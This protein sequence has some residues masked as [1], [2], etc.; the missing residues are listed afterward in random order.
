MAND[1]LKDLFKGKDYPEDAFYLEK[2]LGRRTIILYGAGES[3]HWFVEVVIKGYGFTPYIVLDR[4]FTEESTF[5][6]IPAIHPDHFLATS[7]QLDESIIVI[8]SGNQKTACEIEQELNLK[9]F[10]HIISLHNIYEIH[11]PFS[12]PVELFDDGFSYYLNRESDIKAAYNLLADEESQQVFL[13]F[14]ETHMKRK[15]VDI[16]RRPREEQYFPSDVLL[17]KGYSRFVSCGAYDGDT[18]RALIQKN[19]R[20]EE[21]VCFEADPILFKRLSNYLADNKNEIADKVL[22]L[23]CAVYSHEDIV[24]FTEA[25]GLGS[26]ISENGNLKV[27]TVSL[28]K[29]LP[30]FSPTMI[31]MDIEGVELEALQGAEQ[32]IRTHKPDLAICVYH[33]PN[34]IW[35]IPMYLDSLD[36]GYKFYLRNYT[37]FSLETVLYATV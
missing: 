20:V 34:Q 31:T 19:G 23:P 4:R 35:D 1:K 28:D 5:E 9:G 7:Q 29:I 6:G 30:T 2:N 36:L 11:N 10:K 24:C 14:L 17:N 32:I 12:Q 25:T 21:I 26:R 18:I 16:P 13:A 33:S 3:A 22:A 37:S 15:P 27:Q 8:S